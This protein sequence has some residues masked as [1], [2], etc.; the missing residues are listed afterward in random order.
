[1]DVVRDKGELNW[2]L[3]LGTPLEYS[4]WRCDLKDTLESLA[5]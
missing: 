4:K 5:V 3:I 2:S 1:M